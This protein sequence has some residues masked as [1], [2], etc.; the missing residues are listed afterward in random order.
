MMRCVTLAVVLLAAAF[1][2]VVGA[3]RRGAGAARKHRRHHKDSSS[4][5]MMTTTTL[6]AGEDSTNSSVCS[7]DPAAAGCAGYDYG[8]MAAVLRNKVTVEQLQTLAA[9]AERVKA[10]GPK[11]LVRQR[12]N[13]G[14]NATYNEG[15]EVTYLH[16][17]VKEHETEMLWKLALAADATMPKWGIASKLEAPSWK[18][19]NL[20]TPT[21]RCLEAIDYFPGDHADSTE[22]SL[23]WHNDGATFYTLAIGLTTAS[24]DFDGGELQVRAPANGPIKTVSD[25]QRGDL[26][27]WRGWDR[28]RV[29][30]VTRGQ[31]QV[32][33]A[34]WWLGPSAK[35]ERLTRPP[36]TADIVRNTLPLGAHDS[37]TL[38]SILARC[39]RTLLPFDQLTANN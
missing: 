36:E 12:R 25:L 11:H 1:G 5:D 16:E 19:Q 30:P 32:I 3:K 33:V 4:S 13:F 26:V 38:N 24:T 29:R 9:L 22:D 2:S 35:D 7:A 28:H 8:E 39:D 18:L 10:G 31:R 27:A 37:G 20:P 21:L 14:D 34:E 15:H 23:G 6:T 17:A